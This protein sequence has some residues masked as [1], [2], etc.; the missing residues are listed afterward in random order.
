MDQ[1]LL[2]SFASVSPN[3]ALLDAAR[4]PKVVPLLKKNPGGYLSLYQGKK[5]KELAYYA[6][7]LAPVAVGDTWTR[8]LLRQ[9]WG[10]SWGVFL[11]APGSGPEPLREHLRKLLYVSDHRQR[12]LYFRFYDPRVMRTFLPICTAEQAHSFFGPIQSFLL[13]GGS[14]RDLLLFRRG[15]DGVEKLTTTVHAETT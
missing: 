4:S 10:A 9:S 8:D 6:P 7:Y 5:V 3:Y 13:E 12:R 15:P 14:A 11:V 1:N 2:E